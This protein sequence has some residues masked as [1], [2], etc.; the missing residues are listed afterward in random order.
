MSTFRLASALGAVLAVSLLSAPKIYADT[1][2][3]K[4]EVTFYQPM[5]VPGIV[6]E[7][8]SYIFK[9]ADSAS[10]R[11]TIQVFNNEET[12][13]MASF[14]AVAN[15]RLLPT[16]DS[17]FVFWETLQGWPQAVRAWFCPGDNFAREFQYSP[18]EATTLSAVI[19]QDVALL[20]AEQQDFDP[21]QM[22]DPIRNSELDALE[23][24]APLM[25]SS[26]PNIPPDVPD[27]IAELALE[28]PPT[29]DAA[30]M[31]QLDDLAG[32]ETIIPPDIPPEIEELARAVETETIERAGL[33]DVTAAAE[34]PSRQETFIPAGVRATIAQLAQS[35]PEMSMARESTRQ[36]ELPKTASF[37]PLTG[38]LGLL[39]LGAASAIRLFRS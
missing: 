6:L 11:D 39:S 4:S 18:E 7:P 24:V 5:Q 29:E 34:T 33:P 19:N 14:S 17:R 12:R 3:N 10:G 1:S 21:E 35:R 8:G 36:M 13:L 9:L 28:S 25:A 38:L 2:D 16:E 20:T 26:Q 27:P 15:Q 37:L 22:P 32:E 23:P 31:R 30:A